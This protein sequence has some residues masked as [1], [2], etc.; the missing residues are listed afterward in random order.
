MTWFGFHFAK[1]HATVK[2]SP[3]D[4]YDSLACNSSIPIYTDLQ[5]VQVN[6]NGKISCLIKI[7]H[8][9]ALY[10]HLSCYCTRHITSTETFWSEK[11]TMKKIEK[12]K[13]QKNRIKN[14]WKPHRVFHAY[15]SII[16]Y[17]SRQKLVGSSSI[18]VQMMVSIVVALFSI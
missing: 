8:N 15:F 2:F 7:P 16:N 12:K 3:F 6:C 13:K 18:F 10:K 1:L 11:I 5:L 4:F 17:Q 9:F 14:K